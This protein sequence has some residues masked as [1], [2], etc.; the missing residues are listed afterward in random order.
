MACE[1][2]GSS[3]SSASVKYQQQERLWQELA[4][5]HP[6]AFVAMDQLE[7]QLGFHFQ[8]RHRL[9]EALTHKSCLVGSLRELPWNERLEFLG[10][11]V[12]GLAITSLLWRTCSP[13]SDEGILSRTRAALVSERSLAQVGRQLN[14]SPCIVVS[15]S[16][17]AATYR[18]SLLADALEALIG[19]IYLDA[20]Y[21]K[22]LEIVERLFLDRLKTVMEEGIS[23]DYKS[24][25]Q[26]LI[27]SQIQQAPKYVDIAHT[28]PDHEKRFEVAVIVDSKQVAKGFGTSKKRASQEAAKN[29]LV[30][31]GKAAESRSH[32]IGA[33]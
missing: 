5:K 1:L 21:H 19:A 15:R 17:R 9:Y 16:E 27:Q 12:V 25:L 29:A 26:E 8:N 10:D 31:L 13:R 2:S 18:D 14:L 11:A 6:D 32:S 24:R 20:G 23:D 22:T 7:T 3:Q 4:L 30:A 28:G 33:S